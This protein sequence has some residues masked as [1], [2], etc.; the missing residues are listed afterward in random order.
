MRYE[1]RVG[2]IIQITI[3]KVPWVESRPSKPEN[4]EAYYSGIALQVISSRFPL[5]EPT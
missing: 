2:D 4:V 3:G 5:S 1:L